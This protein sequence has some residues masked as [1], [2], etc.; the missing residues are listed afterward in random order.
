M[1]S[2][3]DRKPGWYADAC[4]LHHRVK[5]KGNHLKTYASPREIGVGVIGYG[6][7]H[8]MG[9]THLKEMKRAGMRLSA[10]CEI[11]AERLKAAQQDFPGIAAYRDLDEMLRKAEVD[12]IAHITP[13]KLHYPLA[14]KCVRAG[15]HVVTEKPFVINTAEADKLIALAKKHRV[16]VSTYHN[17]HW[18]GWIMRARQQ[19][20]E[21]GVIGDVVRVEA[22]M[23]RYGRPGAQWRSSKSMSGGIL[24][25]WG[26]HLIEYA[27]QI[28]PAPI[29]SVAGFAH[30]G[31]WASQ[32]PKGYPW[33]KDANEDHAA[34]IVRFAN[35]CYLN[36]SISTLRATPAPYQIEFHGTKGCY[37]INFKDGWTTRIANAKH[38]LV[39]KTG[40][41]P[42]GKSRLF[43][44]NV[45]DYLCGKE[46]LVITPQY[47]RR[48]IHILDLANR[49]A[50]AGK[51]MEAK[52]G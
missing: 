28:V 15:K 52:Y 13:H 1:R 20:V 10:V 16:M 32:Q 35:G 46:E 5:M 29:Q 43:Y 11:D 45:A 22:H 30:N 9:R 33:K 44:K 40:K 42:A 18:D 14:A 3:C 49:S 23:G 50:K 39:E 17:R 27:L 8:N 2:A 6:G 41:H 47:A 38:E 48:P 34:A 26:V 21:R 31:Y 37:L 36:L 19:I 24:Y 12:L 25:D 51:A 7:V 4:R